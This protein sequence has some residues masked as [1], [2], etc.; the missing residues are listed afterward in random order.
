LQ[1]LAGSSALSFSCLFVGF[2]LGSSFFY[3]LKRFEG[4]QFRV[5]P[6]TFP[7]GWA[8]AC[9][10]FRLFSSV[11]PPL[12][13][14]GWILL[15]LNSLRKV[16]AVDLDRL[17][18][19]RLKS[20]KTALTYLLLFWYLG[21]DVSH[22]TMREVPFFTTPSQVLPPLVSA[23]SVVLIFPTGDLSA[24]VG[25][26]LFNYSVWV[27]ALILTFK[28]NCL[29][30]EISF[31]PP[32]CPSL[33]PPSLLFSALSPEDFSAFGPFPLDSGALAFFSFF[34]PPLFVDFYLLARILASVPQL[35]PT[36]R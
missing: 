28:T 25:F 10:F 20:S 22:V 29:A 5:P 11:F 9:N 13:C 8:F 2:R 16:T 35:C 33:E 32:A 7:F 14:F 27:F 31:Q 18:F 17:L 23:F 1:S 30:I 36:T 15:G 4:L 6:S 26:F 3:S 12:L 34:H 24:F 21:F 19:L